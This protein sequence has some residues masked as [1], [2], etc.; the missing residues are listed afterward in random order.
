TALLGRGDGTFTAAAPAL[1]GALP[2]ALAAADLDGDGRLDLV[3]GLGDHNV[4][5]SPG[6]I[7]ALLGRGDGTFD[8]LAPVQVAPPGVSWACDRVRVGDLDR[9]GKPDVVASCETA[10]VPGQFDVA[11]YSLRQTGGGHFA[12]AVRVADDPGLQACAL[13]LAD[14]NRDGALDALFVGGV[15]LGDGAGGFRPLAATGARAYDAIV[16]GDFTGTGSIDLASS[17]EER[18]AL[19][20]GRGDGSFAAP[21]TFATGASP[22]DLAAADF[23]GDRRLDLAVANYDGFSVTLLIG[24]PGG[25]FAASLNFSVGEQHPSSVAAGD[26]DGDGRVDLAV[27]DRQ[28]VYVLLNR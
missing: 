10:Q 26:F 25:T 4:T 18:V 11:L 21:L 15:A 3:V 1:A 19:S 20:L 7:A 24:A 8:A 23:D 17:D 6:A 14:V 27:A 12:S 16:S 13:E 22:W 5:P 9:D 2:S 28:S